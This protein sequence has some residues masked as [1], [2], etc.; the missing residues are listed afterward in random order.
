MFMELINR[1]IL[2]ATILGILMVIVPRKLNLLVPWP[3]KVAQ[4]NDFP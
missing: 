1:Y 4:A 2:S 3:E